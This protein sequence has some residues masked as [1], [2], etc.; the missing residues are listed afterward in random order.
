MKLSPIQIEVTQDDLAKFWRAT[1][2]C[3]PFLLIVASMAASVSDVH[4]PAGADCL[5][6]VLVV[7]GIQLRVS[8]CTQVAS[9]QKP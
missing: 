7:G 8:A 3:L 1:R 5:A 9:G 2:R 6:R 4:R